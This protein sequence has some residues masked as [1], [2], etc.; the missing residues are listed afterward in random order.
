[1][2]KCAMVSGQPVLRDDNKGQTL[3]TDKIYVQRLLE[4]GQV[5]DRYIEK[6]QESTQ[7]ST[8]LDI[9]DK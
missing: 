9:V 3:S 5:W 7:G 6:R 8:M 1:M 2:Y 4:N